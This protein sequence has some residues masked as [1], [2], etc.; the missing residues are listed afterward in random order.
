MTHL[1]GDLYDVEDFDQDMLMCCGDRLAIGRI[2]WEGVWAV[3]LDLQEW[4][5]DWVGG[6]IRRQLEDDIHGRLPW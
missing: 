6:P 1:G 5:C 2:T 3:R 4:I